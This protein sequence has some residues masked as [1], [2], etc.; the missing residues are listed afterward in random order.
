MKTIQASWILS[1]IVLGLLS[2]VLGGWIRL[3][4]VA[5]PLGAA[6]AH[7]GLLMVGCFLGALI[8]LERA[9]VMK[10]KYGLAVPLSSALSMFFLLGG[11]P[12]LGAF[13][14]LAASLGLVVLMYFQTLKVPEI[15]TYIIALGAAAW[16]L[17]NFAYIYSD[18]VPMATGWWMAFLLF[19]ILGE[20]MELNKF[21]PTPVWA[22][23]VFYAGLAVFGLG[24]LLPFHQWGNTVLGAA[25]LILSIWLVRF[26]MAR[27]AAK[28]SGQFRYIGIGLLTGYFWLALNG[29]ILGWMEGHSFYYDLYLH[30]FFLGFTFSMIWA[31]APIIFPAVFRIKADVF[32][33]VLWWGWGIFQISLAARVA[34]SWAGW[35]SWRY[36][37]GMVNGFSI[38]ALFLSMGLIVYFRWK[39]NASIITV[40]LAGK[41]KIIRSEEKMVSSK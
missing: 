23:Y 11:W 21:L 15:Y 16:M 31:H 3:G 33:P 27:F 37:F 1:F 26:D 38:L 4:F 41:A 24:L 17:G 28:K 40:D 13:L 22:K 20:R 29:W 36:F 12:I 14:L 30:T 19:T 34:S 18:F 2:G 35:T 32:H 10:N 25:L 5:I 7:H 9:M 8:S 6:A 39:V